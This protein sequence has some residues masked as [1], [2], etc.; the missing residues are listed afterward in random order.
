MRTKY[1]KPKQKQKARFGSSKTSLGPTPIDLLP[2]QD[3]T[4]VVGPECYMVLYYVHAYIVS[5]NMVS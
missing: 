4:S 2:F 1:F 3:G 5:T